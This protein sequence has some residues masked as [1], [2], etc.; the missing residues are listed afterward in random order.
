MTSEKYKKE[1]QYEEQIRYAKA[2]VCARSDN[3]SLFFLTISYELMFFI[4]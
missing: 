3:L 4:L 2:Y 1:K